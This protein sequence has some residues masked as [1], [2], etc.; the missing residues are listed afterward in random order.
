MQLVIFFAWLPFAKSFL[1]NN[2]NKPKILICNKVVQNV[3]DRLNLFDFIITAPKGDEN[4]ITIGIQMSIPES[5]RL[6][7]KV[8]RVKKI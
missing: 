7:K 4:L 6:L 3:A 1:I 2:S 8:K 5:L